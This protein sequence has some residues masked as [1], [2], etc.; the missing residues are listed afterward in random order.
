MMLLEEGRF[1]EGRIHKSH[2]GDGRIAHAQALRLT[3]EG[4][5]LL[6]KIRSETM[7]NKIKTLAKEKGLE[8]T[9]DTVKALAAVALTSILG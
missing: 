7:W 2:T 9:F 6:D 4:H 1:I 5:E 8:L 3:W